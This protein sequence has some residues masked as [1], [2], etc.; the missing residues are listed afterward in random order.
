MAHLRNDEFCLYTGM[1]PN[2]TECFEALEHMKG[3][4]VQFR[5]LHY[6]DPAQIPDVMVSLQTWFPG[7]TLSF[8]MMVYTECYDYSDPVSRVARAVVG[9]ANIKATDWNAL[10]SFSGA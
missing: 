2:A 10:T 7:E 8:P 6:G 4:G 9:V 1:T 3:L 5:H